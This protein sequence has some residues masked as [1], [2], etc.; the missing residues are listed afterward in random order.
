MKAKTTGK[1]AKK[2]PTTP[3]ADPL[4]PSKAAQAE[5]I[6]GAES[7]FKTGDR[8][9]INVIGEAAGKIGVIIE[10]GA[11]E[12]GPYYSV[13]TDGDGI[14]AWYL[15][16]DDLELLTDESEETIETNETP[17]GTQPAKTE[18][19]AGDSGTGG[20]EIEINETP[21]KAARAA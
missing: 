17:T 12:D 9:R 2:P 10:T 7:K 15:S 3:A 19:T 13:R 14:K 1:K 11:D 6:T 18:T 16:D 4:P 21:I 20:G 8:V 5:G